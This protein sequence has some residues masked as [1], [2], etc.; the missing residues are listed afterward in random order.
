MESLSRNPAAH[1]PSVRGVSRR[2]LAS[3]NPGAELPSL[4]PRVTSAAAPAPI[5]A[6]AADY[7]Q[8]LASTAPMGKADRSPA[9]IRDKHIPPRAGPPPSVP[10]STWHGHS[11]RPRAPGACPA[12]LLPRLATV[13]G[14][15]PVRERDSDEE[16]LSSFASSPCTPET[17]PESHIVQA[18]GIIS[19]ASLPRRVK[20]PLN[21][22]EVKAFRCAVL[23]QH[24]LSCV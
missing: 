20:L 10:R 4:R 5:G 9:R 14:G 13:A 12:C 1:P 2:P 17:V 18:L 22:D 19:F 21:M 16:A 8:R 7:Q 24:S 11:Q 23:L 15:R 3:S 6:A